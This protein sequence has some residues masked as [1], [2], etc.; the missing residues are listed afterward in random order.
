MLDAWSLRVLVEVADRGSFSAA[1]AALSMTQPAVSRQV[2]GLERRLGAPLF[3]RLPRGI[4]PT[5]P[6]EVAVAM[7]RDVL[8]RMAALEARLGAF[9][10]LET[11][12]LRLSAFPSANT[13][14]VPEAMRRFALAHPGVA[15]SLARPAPDGP[16]PELRAGRVDVALATSWDLVAEPAAAKR[17]PGVPPLTADDLPDLDL[18]PL[19]DEE[20]C[21]ALPADHPLAGRAV[22]PLAGLRDA[23]WIEGGHPDCLGPIPRLAEALGAPPRVGLFCDDW[24]GKQAMVAAGAG[25]TVVPTSARAAI[26]PGVV[27]RP[28]APALPTRGLFALSAAPRFRSPAATAMLGVLGA[29]AATLT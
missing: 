25:V 26:R 22:V 11:G 1:A 12:E 13:G 7:A 5:P 16:L 21:V 19:M 6:G 18:V 20:L 29:V 28:T 4:R 8:A 10:A 9:A 24:N 17:E 23:V 14:L 3:Q 15:L 27:L 2:G